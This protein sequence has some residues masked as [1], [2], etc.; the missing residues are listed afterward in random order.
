MPRRVAH[1]DVKDIQ[2]FARL[3]IPEDLLTLARVERVTDAEAREEFGILFDGPLDGIVFPYY[4]DGKR[5]TARV[6]RDHPEHDSKGKPQNK[7]VSAYGDQRHLYVPPGYEARLADPQTV[8]I[9]VEAEKSVLAIEAWAQRMKISRPVLP[10]GCGGCWGWKGKVG[11]RTDANGERE[12]EK[13]ALPEV[14]WARDGRAAAIIFDANAASN[15]KVAHARK[16]LVEQLGKQGA[17]ISVIDLPALDGVNG[18]DDFIAATSD[19][20]FLDLLEGKRP[21]SEKDLTGQ[22][23]N[24]Y[25]N[26]R[27]LIEVHG[28][29][30][31]YCPPMKKWLIWDSRRFQIDEVDLIRKLTQQVMLEF[32][33]QAL[34]VANDVL[35][36][37]AGASLNSQRIS[38]C[39]RE[40]QPLLA[41][42]ADELDRNL[43]LLNFRNGTL[44]LQSF[45]L[46]P[47]SRD[48]LITKLV[49]H[50][51]DAHAKCPRFLAFLE[52]SVGAKLV[53][54]LQ[55]AFGYSLTGVT[56]EKKT[57]LCVGPGD[58]GKTTLLSLARDLFEEY[59]TLILIDCLMQRDEDNNSRAD[60]ADLRGVRFAITSE[61]EQGQRLRESKLKRI[62]TGGGRIKSVK[63]YEHPIE[64]A[65][66]HKL[67]I[68][69]NHKPVVRG[70]DSAIWDRFAPIPFDRPLAESEI[71]RQLPAKLREEAEGIIAW[72]LEGTLLWQREGL[73]QPIE[74]RYARHTWRAEMDRLDAFRKECCTE[75]AEL[76][77]RARALYKAYREWSEEAGERPMTETAFGLRMTEDGFEKSRDT[78]GVC[79]VGIALRDLFHG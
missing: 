38:S 19:E 36:R 74:V 32:A 6:R 27:R 50:N 31:R 70:T 60:L 62:T 76:S 45:E 73:G 68:D 58:T 37:F 40:A 54:F 65:E 64:F 8:F 72:M 43:W 53:P 9:Y 2:D 1:L 69:C 17:R 78:K 33:R 11:I 34:A 22:P 48:H 71:D 30:L 63:K 66:T 49:H 55:R 7:Y 10:F 52:R 16:K 26:A 35:A 75:D 57:F 4:I 24:D 44:D 42:S 51:Y 14:G 41:V 21:Q 39:I 20:I 13:G 23:L 28:D 59:S 15:P 5:V 18:V 46:L 79:Y 12:A 29:S 61:T 47:H 3:R 25:G 67:W 77:V 56:S